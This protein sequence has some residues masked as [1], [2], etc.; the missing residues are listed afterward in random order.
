VTGTAYRPATADA[1]PAEDDWSVQLLTGNDALVGLRDEWDDLYARSRSATPFQCH[2]W[3]ESWWAEY[4]TAGR[5]RLVL[6]RRDGEL[7]AAAPL[8]L[9]RRGPYRVLL[10]LGG[11][12]SD[13][14]DVLLDPAAGAGDR[15]AAAVRSVPGWDVL[16]L[17]EVRAGAAAEQLFAAWTGSRWRT[18]GAMCLELRAGSLADFVDGL[19][20]HTA[21]TVK[22]KLRKIQAAPITAVSTPPADVP[23]TVRR[24]LELHEGQWQGRPIDAE[25]LRPRFARHL[26]RALG[27]MVQ[28]GQAELTRYELAG[29]PVVVDLEVVGPDFVG[30][31]LAGFDPALREQVDVAVL[32][33]SRAFGLAERRGQPV[34]S[35]LRGDEPYKSHWHPVRARNQRLLL[36]RPGRRA[37]AA[38]YAGLVLARR[39]AADAAKQ[40]A[41]WLREARQRLRS[42]AGRIG[43]LRR[44]AGGA[45]RL[46]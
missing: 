43:R 25:H 44:A 13:Y 17:S 23:A 46:G 16:D 21:K 22:R 42:Y 7:V 2:A 32:M 41:P 35:L 29:R 10:P 38:G 11:D 6:L 34:L 3:L 45:G 15:L 37:A 30:T 8:R 40:R 18:R 5:L 31:Y 28:R 33:L 14:H 12:E 19:P 4:G 9:A 20:R 36:G 27:A 1:P 26:S 24:L 39:A